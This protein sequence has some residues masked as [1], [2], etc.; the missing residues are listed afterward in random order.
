MEFFLDGVQ[1]FFTFGV[2]GVVVVARGYVLQQ[3]GF[4]GADLFH[5][6][7]DVPAGFDSHVSFQDT[8]NLVVDEYV[9]DLSAGI[10]DGA[11]LFFYLVICVVDLE[12]SGIF[13]VLLEQIAFV[14][15]KNSGS[16]GTQERN[17]LDNN[18]AADVLFP[19]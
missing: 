2:D 3:A 1:D 11:Q 4:S 14:G 8:V 6:G 16:V 12:N 10:Y 5:V 7:A 13:L 19:R 9:A 15:G 18:L 17:I